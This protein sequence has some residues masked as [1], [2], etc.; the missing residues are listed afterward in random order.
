VLRLIATIVH[1]QNIL[2]YRMYD[3]NKQ[4]FE[5]LSYQ[6]TIAL[7]LILQFI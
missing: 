1:D 2:A 5:D 6:E 3:T 4:T 7:L